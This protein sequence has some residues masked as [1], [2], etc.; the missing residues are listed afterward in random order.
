MFYKKK[1]LPDD[2]ELVICTVKKVLPHSVF[3]S[4]DEYENLE[5]MMH[6]SEVSPGRIRNIRDFVIEGKK[7]VC[8]VLKVNPEKNHVDLSLRRVT[9][10]QKNKK[11]E[12]YKQEEKAEKI[13]ESLAKNLKKDVKE[14]YE[15]VGNELMAKYGSLTEAFYSIVKD[16]ANLD[17]L[18]IP[19][20]YKT[21]LK[22]IANEK[23]SIPEV[24]ISG[25]LILK[26]ESGNGIDK[27]KNILIES[28]KNAKRKGYF[29]NLKYLSAPSYRLEVISSDFKNAER[30]LKEIID[31]IS[32]DSIKENVFFEFKRW[33]F[34]FVKTVASIL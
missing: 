11:N 6:I 22:K 21:E 33:K 17:S 20:E 7:L 15:K 5:G 24:K 18:N 31:E 3:V 4:I 27:I 10:I 29:L 25:V 12:V 14:I 9:L 2:A 23:I 13:L 26:S 16:E 34:F 30:A 8:K 28:K 1:G 19:K 32:S